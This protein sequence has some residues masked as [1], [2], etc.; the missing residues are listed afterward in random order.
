MTENGKSRG[1]EET[2]NIH[3]LG[4]DHLLCLREGAMSSMGFTTL[5]ASFRGGYIC[6][7]ALSRGF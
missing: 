1:T 4:N 5:N 7:Y 3:Y 2:K 6:F